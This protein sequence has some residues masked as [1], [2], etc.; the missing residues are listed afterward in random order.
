MDSI[1]IGDNIIFFVMKIITYKIST[2][3]YKCKVPKSL[4]LKSA[5]LFMLLCACALLLR[6]Q[7]SCAA[8]L[9]YF[10]QITWCNVRYSTKHW[11]CKT[12]VNQQSTLWWKSFSESSKDYKVKLWQKQS[13]D[14]TWTA[15]IAQTLL[16][17]HKK[18][19]RGLQW[20]SISLVIISIVG[21]K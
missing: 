17:S 16:K 21:T 11:Q 4:C 9:F 12:L 18:N 3:I 19:T 10:S 2:I 7:Q 6:D 8:I 20:Y 14:L 15:F 13:C 1:T 5:E